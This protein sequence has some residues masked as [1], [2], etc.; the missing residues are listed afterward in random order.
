MQ[1]NYQGDQPMDQKF[2]ILDFHGFRLV[3][4]AVL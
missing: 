1:N 2:S 4:G 3:T